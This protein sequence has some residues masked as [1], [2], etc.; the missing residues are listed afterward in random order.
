MIIT[1][2]SKLHEPCQEVSIDIGF[3]IID[4]LESELLKSA[5]RGIGLAANQ[6]GIPKKVCILRIPQFN[7]GEEIVIGYNLINPII[8][9]KKYPMKVKNEGCL[10][11]PGQSLETLRYYEIVVQDSLEPH[12][13]LLTDWAAICCQHE[14]DHLNGITMHDRKLNRIGMNDKCPCGSG[15]KFKK[16]CHVG[17]TQN[18][19]VLE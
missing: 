9:S 8:I 1:D 16:C 7:L 10:S 12:G 5:T 15:M 11:Y 4:E 17:L 13:R 2:D 3:K 19:F 18:K 14:V 6:I